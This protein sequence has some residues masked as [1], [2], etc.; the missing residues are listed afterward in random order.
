MTTLSPSCHEIREPQGLSRPATGI[1]YLS[2]HIKN[3]AYGTIILPVVLRGCKT[4]YSA[5][6]NALSLRVFE[7][8][9]LK[10]CGSKWK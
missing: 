3:V 1:A 10:M 4:E 8:R 7:D 5:L 2:K 6:M 9:V